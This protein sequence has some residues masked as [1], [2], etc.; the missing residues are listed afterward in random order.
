MPDSTFAG[1]IF[2][3]LFA[4]SFVAGHV[5]GYGSATRYWRSRHAMEDQKIRSVIAWRHEQALKEAR[6]DL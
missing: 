1:W 6:N 4:A 2:V 3:F 5:V